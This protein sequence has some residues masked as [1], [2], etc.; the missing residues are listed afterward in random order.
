MFSSFCYF[1][2]FFYVCVFMH[3]STKQLMALAFHTGTDACD[4]FSYLLFIRGNNATPVKTGTGKQR[5]N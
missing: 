5:K 1:I 4:F 2:Y 3:R